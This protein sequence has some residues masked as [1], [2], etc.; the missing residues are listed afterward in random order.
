MMAQS[1]APPPDQVMQ[2]NICGAG[3]WFTTIKDNRCDLHAGS[4]DN[5][6]ALVFISAKDYQDWLDHKWQIGVYPDV[7]FHEYGDNLLRQLAPRVERNPQSASSA[8][9]CFP[10]L[11]EHVKQPT[12]IPGCSEGQVAV[13]PLHSA[14]RCPPNSNIFQMVR[15]I[16]GNHLEVPALSILPQSDFWKDLGA[17]D[18]DG[19][20]LIM[21]AEEHFDI[22][23]HDD[24]AMKIRTMQDMVQVVQAKIC[25]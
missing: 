19:T 16:V 24:E 12:P 2:L 4:T 23:I 10:I 9:S 17:D 21:V 6:S 5:P 7:H 14:T 18:L 3:Q 15:L 13:S 25:P 22:Q 11:P 1:H 8:D 20:E